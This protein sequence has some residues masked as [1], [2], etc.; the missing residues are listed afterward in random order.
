MNQMR[1]DGKHLISLCLLVLAAGVVIKAVRWQLKSALFPMVVGILVMIMA[2]TVLL[3]GFFRREKVDSKQSTMDFEFSEHMDKRLAIRRTL[4][5][6]SWIIG[7]FAMIIFFGF[8]IS[9]PLYIFLYLKLY[10]K[11]K[12]GISLIIAASSWVF[13]YSLF[14]RLLDIPMQEGWVVKWLEVIGII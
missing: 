1:Y 7:F 12:W 3:L 13:F 4:L 6:S 14:V 2:I 5:T 9:V 10:G 8:S 11:E